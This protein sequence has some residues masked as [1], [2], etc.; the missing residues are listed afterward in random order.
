MKTKLSFSY[1]IAIGVMLFALFFGAGNLIFPAELGQGSGSNLL[2]AIIGFLITG[3]G[4]PLL[5]VL[6]IAYSGS[7]NLQELAGRIHPIYA[8]CFTS[9]LYLTIGPF[10]A[11]P[12]TATVAYEV[13]FQ[14]FIGEG[15]QQIGLFIFSF[16]FFA[17]TL[18]FSLK[19]A[20]LVD[21]VGKILAP[22]I[23]IL[24][25]ILLSLVV[26]KPMGSIEAPLEAYA[27]GA[28]V[29]GF[30]EGYNTMDALA[31]LVFAIIVIKAIRCMGI[32]SK[33]DIIRSTAKAGTVAIIL[34]SV[35]Y[36][37]I[38]YLGATSTHVFGVFENGGPVLSSAST[39]YFGALGTVLLAI[40]ITLACLTTAIGLVTACA[41]YFQTL[42]PKV[43]YSMLVVFFSVLTFVIA[44]FGL[45]NI[46]KYSEPVLMFLYPLAIVLIL[47][48]FLSPLFHHV[49]SVYVSA[50]IVTFLISIV[51]GLKTLARTLEIDNFSWLK[52]ILTFY[53]AVLPLYDEGL[54]WLLPALIVMVITGVVARVY[55]PITASAIRK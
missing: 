36:V 22:G 35:I 16:I 20:K 21:N 2:P 25:A 55:K 4:L 28:F 9:L 46:I 11:A 1:H 44:N 31:S 38:A 50:T 8:L 19:P 51:D 27:N 5:G 18:L 6:A 52:P 39:Y 14:P 17:V 24:L 49:R 3:T 47:L 40:V 54:G 23:V 10:F 33:H 43:S 15:S 7:E 42:L 53:D 29:T 12:R 37:G 32:T 26:I 45:T 34:L 48:T 30:L 41:E 13:G